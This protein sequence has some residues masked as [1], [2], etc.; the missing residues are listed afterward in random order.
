MTRTNTISYIIYSKM[1]R[2]LVLLTYIGVSISHYKMNHDI[3]ESTISKKHWYST[4]IAQIFTNSIKNLVSFVVT[5]CLRQSSEKHY[6]FSIFSISKEICLCK[7]AFRTKVSHKIE[8]RLITSIMEENETHGFSNQNQFTNENTQNQRD[9]S[10][11]SKICFGFGHIFN[12]LCIAIWGSYLLLFLEKVLLMPG[13]AAGGLILFGQIIDATTTPIA[14][15]LCDR[16]GAKR[17][18]HILGKRI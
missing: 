7:C 6:L 15:Y 4:S 12:D 11:F 10:I 9:L 13:G 17:K 2:A 3:N 5:I 8:R 14:G 1:H 18:L 16:F